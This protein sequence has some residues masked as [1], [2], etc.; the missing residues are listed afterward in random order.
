MAEPFTLDSGMK[1]K[2]VAAMMNQY[3][4]DG[5]KFAAEG[6]QITAQLRDD[7]VAQVKQALG[8]GTEAREQLKQRGIN[9]SID[10]NNKLTIDGAENLSLRDMAL[11]AAGIGSQ[12]VQQ[13]LASGD[14][15]KALSAAGSRADKGEMFGKTAD[16]TITPPPLATPTFIPDSQAPVVADAPVTGKIDFAALAGKLGLKL[17]EKAEE[18]HSTDSP[19]RA[20]LTPAVEVTADK[21]RSV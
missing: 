8:E 7:Q 9:V 4:T 11:M 10:S 19:T 15:S 14:I 21:Q 16:G 13:A 12:D 1:L 17:P 2:A 18:G 5:V 3:N 20:P 6:S